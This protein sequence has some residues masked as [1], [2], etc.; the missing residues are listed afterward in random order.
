MASSYLKINA[1]NHIELHPTKQQLLKCS[2][3]EHIVSGEVV[4]FPK[5]CSKT[6]KAFSYHEFTDRVIERY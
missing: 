6:D 4:C 3:K 5:A 2:L 1:L